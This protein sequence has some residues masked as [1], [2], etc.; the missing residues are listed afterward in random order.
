MSNV[1]P[2]VWRERSKCRN[3]TA[4][5]PDLGENTSGMHGA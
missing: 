4:I 5:I 3:P 2:W 1:R